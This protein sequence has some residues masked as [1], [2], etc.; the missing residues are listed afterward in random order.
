MSLLRGPLL[1][2][3]PIYAA[4]SILNDSTESTLNLTQQALI[5]PVSAVSTKEPYPTQKKLFYYNITG[6]V[7]SHTT[8][9]LVVS[10]STSHKRISET[11]PQTTV[12]L[13]F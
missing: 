3:Y 12:F 6:L 5:D 13:A 9:I 11:L 1:G 8:R 2:G 7:V 4:G 10:F